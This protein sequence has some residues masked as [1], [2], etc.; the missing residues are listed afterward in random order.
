MRKEI[1]DDRE[2]G[3]RHILNATHWWD[4]GE[5]GK[6]SVDY[7]NCPQTLF[8]EQYSCEQPGFGT[9]SPNDFSHP[10][11]SVCPCLLGTIEKGKKEYVRCSY[12][13]SPM[14]TLAIIGEQRI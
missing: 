6:V 1:K 5:C 10:D 8:E 9:C 3:V 13:G 7:G 12:S 4:G 2:N 14:G 11:R